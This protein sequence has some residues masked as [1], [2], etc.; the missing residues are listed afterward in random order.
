MSPVYKQPWPRRLERKP[1]ERP[2]G[3]ALG[4]PD[5]VIAGAQKAGT[6]WWYRLVADHPG[7]YR[8][9]GEPKELHY[10]DRFWAAPFTDAEAAF[11]HRYF[12]R[13]PGLATGESTPEYMYHA[14]T[15]GYLKRAAPD[16]RLIVLLRDPIERYR[17]GVTWDLR[18]GAP[19][20]TLVPADAIRRG[21]FHE[22][23]A[24]I[25]AHFD[26]ERL[27]VLQFE[28]MTADPMPD[29]E[30]TYRFLGLHNVSHRPW[31]L[32]TAANV[33]RVQKVP[34]PDS[35]RAT[36]VDVFADDVRRLAADF[37][38]VDLS[39]WPNFKHL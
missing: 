29:L 22:Q 2:D 17:S 6:T 10:F 35:L 37:P 36:L 34:L 12:P 11:Y 5:F 20:H 7:V 8:P 27:L 38:E 19:R 21:F 1:P 18:R 31:A 24:R 26:R 15:P 14:W 9:V 33:T 23:L 39:L 28:R 30:R 3:W 32:D 16:T 25:L 13:P 4:P